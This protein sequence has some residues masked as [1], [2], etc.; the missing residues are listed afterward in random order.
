MKSTGLQCQ[1][2]TNKSRAQ[3]PTRGDSLAVVGCYRRAER[4]D[5]MAT[6]ETGSW[7]VETADTGNVTAIECLAPNGALSTDVQ[8]QMIEVV[9]ADV[10]AGVAPADRSTWGYEY[11]EHSPL[12]SPAFYWL[13]YLSYVRGVIQDG[14][15][16]DS[17]RRTRELKTLESIITD[18]IANNTGADR[19]RGYGGW[20]PAVG[21]ILVDSG[22][23]RF[24]VEEHRDNRKDLDIGYHVALRALGSL[25]NEFTLAYWRDMG[26]LY[27]R[28]A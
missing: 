6:I 24:R 10:A 17:D 21:S 15:Q 25:P 13:S 26:T 28:E 12:G 27:T 5:E 23:H 7:N 16:P 19:I 18:L 3:S 4:G 11:R 8:R 14:D 22:G 1:Q 9:N 20:R 2:D